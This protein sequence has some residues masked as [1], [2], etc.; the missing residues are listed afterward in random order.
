[1]SSTHLTH[2]TFQQHEPPAERLE[3]AVKSIHIEA[4]TIGMYV[5]R[6][7]RPWPENSQLRNK[8]RID[9][10]EDI[11]LLQAHGVCHVTIDPTL[12][13]DVR[14][15]SHTGTFP[16]LD[17]LTRKLVQAREVRAEAMAALQSVFEGV[18]TGAPINSMEVKRAVHAV[19]EEILQLHDPLL[20]LIHIQRNDVNMFAHALN[21]CVYALLVGKMQGFDKARLERLGVGAMLHDVGELRLPRNLL[22]KRE[23]YSEQE[24]RLMQQHPRLGAAM[25]SQSDGIHEESRRIVLE[26]HERPNGSGYPQG[27][28]GLSIAAASEI[29]GIVDIYDAMISD[30]EGRPPLAPAQAIKEIY[31]CGLQ[32]HIDLG[33]AER[34][35]RCLGIYPVGSI[36]ELS[37]H[38]RALVISTNPLNA[39]RPTVRI[40]C[41]ASQQPYAHPI[42][43]DLASLRPQEPERTIVRALDP[44]KESLRVEAYIGEA[45]GVS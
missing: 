11:A 18:R 17:P 42:T 23:V 45:T 40:V 38:E 9:T 34:V 37:T 29:V 19:M 3:M 5:V 1:M 39:L 13:D 33:W 26:H 41:D 35:I 36:V 22:R 25:L 14:A 20:G 7:D 16:E 31:Q 32:G 27:L 10:A 8:H 28:R 24:R 15:G 44:A 43:V 12:G 30:R 6:L 4:L 2:Q 21:V